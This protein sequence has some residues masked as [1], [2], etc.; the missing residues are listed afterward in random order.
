MTICASRQTGD[1]T[2]TRIAMTEAM[3][4]NAVSNEI[5]GPPGHGGQQPAQ[6]CETHCIS[7][8]HVRSI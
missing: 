2:A 8:L 3:R 4:K 7:F 6:M 1:A 5:T